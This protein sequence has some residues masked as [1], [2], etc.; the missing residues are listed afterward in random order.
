MGAAPRWRI[1][2]RERAARQRGLVLAAARAVQAAGRRV[3]SAAEVRPSAG[4]DR[5]RLLPDAGHGSIADV[6]QRIIALVAEAVDA[7]AS[8]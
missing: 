8:R 5:L 7:A 1:H 2:S 4:V 6:P 3:T